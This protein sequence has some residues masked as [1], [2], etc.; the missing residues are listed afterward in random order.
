MGKALRV[1]IIVIFLLGVG[2]LALA[3]M[4]YDKRTEF[5]E[6]FKKF[7]AEIPKIAATLSAEAP[8]PKTGASHEERDTSPVEARALAN[9]ERAR[10]WDIYD[11]AL[12]EPPADMVKYGDPER[13]QIRKLFQT[14][15]GDNGAEKKV[16]D[17][18]TNKPKT[19]GPGTMQELLDKIVKAARTQNDTLLRTCAQLKKIREEYANTVAELN[20]VKNDGRR[21][22][23]TIVDR[24]ATITRLEGDK[25][26]LQQNIR[27]LESE[28]TLLLQE[29]A[30]KEDTIK[31]KNEEIEKLVKTNQQLDNIN[32]NLRILIEQYK[33]QRQ[34]TGALVGDD[35]DDNEWR[36]RLSPGDKGV[37]A[38]VNN[39]L[40]FV[41]LKLDPS[42]SQDPHILGPQLDQNLPAV[43]LGIRRPGFESPSGEF[44]TRVRLRQVSRESHLYIADILMDWQQSSVEVGDIVFFN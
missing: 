37:V 27:A 35:L 21:D 5:A 41:V 33:Q 12:E 1:L 28:K 6:R 8:A 2:A 11:M 39:E 4:L 31:N 24:D 36:R 44:I 29:I 14:E 22:K 3:Y 13:L 32:N 38:A 26:T 18:L 40:K 15:T 19:E 34:G 10:F 25:A 7:E 16:I 43:P 42:F 9:P 17:P 30:E 20:R 23:E